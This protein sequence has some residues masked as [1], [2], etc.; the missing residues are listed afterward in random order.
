MSLFLALIMGKN[1]L[2]LCMPHNLDW[3]PD[4]VNFTLWGATYFL[5]PRTILE[6]YSGAQ[7]NYLKMVQSFQV[8]S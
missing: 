8:C 7:F 3:I 6:P 1:F 2:L 5:I 4:T